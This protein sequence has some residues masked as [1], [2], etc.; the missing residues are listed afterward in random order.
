MHHEE[1]RQTDPH[2]A[3]RRLRATLDRLSRDLATANLDGLLAC[4]ADLASALSDLGDRSL[5]DAATRGATARELRAARLALTRC[6]RLGATLGD[7]TRLSLAAR[8]AGP[9]Y[10]RFGETRTHLGVHALE[11]KV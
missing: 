7:L 1:D 3:A 5:L 6:R 8:G 9:S 10:G 2:A 11:A 4:E